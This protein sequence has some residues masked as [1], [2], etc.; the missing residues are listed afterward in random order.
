LIRV[1]H[2]MWRPG[3][4]WAGRNTQAPQEV[5]ARSP[6]ARSPVASSP[7]AIK[8][9]LVG[10][11]AVGKAALAATL[12]TASVAMTW[13]MTPSVQATPPYQASTSELST[14]PESSRETWP[15]V[16]ASGSRDLSAPLT[17][18]QQTQ[19]HMGMSFGVVLYAPNATVA[20]QA[21]QEAFA[22]IEALNAIFSDYDPASEVSRLC[23]RAPTEQPVPVSRELAEVLAAAHQLS[24]QTDG[25]FDVTVGPLTK[26]WRRARRNYQ[27]PDP[28]RLQ[29]EQAAVGFDK[30]T[31]DPEARTVQLHVPRMRLDFGGIVPGYAADEA[32][33][34]L[35]RHGCTRALINASGDLTLGD[36]PPGE[37][38]WKIDIAP[39]EP[40][41][42]P[43]RTIRLA[44]AA[45]STSGD[46]FQ[47]VEI[48]GRRYSHI[49][50]PRTGYGLTRR[51]SVTVIAP[52]GLLADSLATAVSILGPE[53]GLELIEKR[54][55]T[56]ALLVLAPEPSQSG[57]VTTIE[58]RRFA[59]Y[60]Q[61]EPKP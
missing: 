19:V 15:P 21:L 46:A 50:D 51:S 40:K 35:A 49:V 28:E 9:A 14:E 25:A 58:S 11:V 41:G 33:K 57:Q 18:F 56:A 30:M 29:Q 52:N 3:R 59:T 44:N 47:F 31:V 36:P 1:V 10:V 45:V 48:D 17:R 20:N 12:V 39:L 2:P 24:R 53:R 43:S 8:Q 61:G 4:G 26:L 27:L 54:Q 38:G 42:K 34:V 37:T 16:T 23:D 60:C 5:T 6:V 32:L 7:V 22:R 13:V 55:G